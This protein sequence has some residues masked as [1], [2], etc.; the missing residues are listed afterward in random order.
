MSEADSTAP[1]ALPEMH[2]PVLRKE[3]AALWQAYFRP[4]LD[5]KPLSAVQPSMVPGPG[6]KPGN[7]YREPA[8]CPS[9]RPDLPQNGQL[10]YV[11]ATLGEAGHARLLL[12]QQPQAQLL[13]IDADPQMLGRARHFLDAALGSEQRQQRCRFVERRF[14][15]Y[16]CSLDPGLLQADMIL[17]DLG[18][19]LFHYNSEAARGFSF[20]PEDPEELLDM[21]LNPAQGQSA[22]ELLQTL[23]EAELADILYSYGELRNSRRLAR[24][25]VAQRDNMELH[26]AQVLAHFLRQINPTARPG[27][28]K[29]NGKHNKGNKAKIHPAT[30]VFQALRIAVGDELGQLKSGLP[31]ALE[32]LRTY[33]LLAVITFHSLED[34]LVKQQFRDWQ[35]Q[36]RVQW[37]YKKTI[38]ASH[39]S[40]LPSE[41]SAK[42]RVVRRM[43]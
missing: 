35:D 22:A 10:L 20:R 12:E 2:K 18:I 15:D 32:Q 31:A 39:D 6:H 40:P 37:V 28:K 13:G 21:R 19:S 8:P 1:A 3:V 7:K 5:E 23:S 4:D 30:Q 33:G 14:S 26:K 29:Q 25:I 9:I 36:G 38:Q 41:R 11:D 43:D 17:F 42:L 16:F 24:L 34:R 27:K